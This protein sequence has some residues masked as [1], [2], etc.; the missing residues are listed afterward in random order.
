MEPLFR[1]CDQRG[2]VLPLHNHFQR[3]NLRFRMF[4]KRC[5]VAGQLRFPLD[6]RLL[7]MCAPR[8]IDHPARLNHALAPV[9]PPHVAVT[10]LKGGVNN[11]NR[12]PVRY[13]L[14]IA[15]R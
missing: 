13:I 2:N 4:K 7:N 10:N 11:I 15:Q 12:I 9:V 8:L 1:E 5:D 14:E 3:T 6:Q